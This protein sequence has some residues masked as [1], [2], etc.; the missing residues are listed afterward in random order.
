MKVEILK[1]DWDELDFI[2]LLRTSYLNES[3]KCRPEVVM[4]LYWPEKSK[5]SYCKRL[6]CENCKI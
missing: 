3:L 2:D 5:C 1:I 4:S 6:D